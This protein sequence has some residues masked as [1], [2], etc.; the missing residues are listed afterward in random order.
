MANN[1]RAA[2][3]NPVSPLQAFGNMPEVKET[4]KNLHEE[5]EQSERA[6][7]MTPVSQVTVV[8]QDPLQ[9]AIAN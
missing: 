1:E 3:L 6:V 7:R 5:Y 8:H 2:T 4:Q 9:A